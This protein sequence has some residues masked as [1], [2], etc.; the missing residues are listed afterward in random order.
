[1]VRADACEIAESLKVRS[2]DGYNQLFLSSNFLSSV[3]NLPLPIGPGNARTGLRGSL[4]LR[5]A[6]REPGE[7]R[8]INTR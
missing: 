1:M 2:S 5:S 6:F 7:A 8:T 4:C 3:I